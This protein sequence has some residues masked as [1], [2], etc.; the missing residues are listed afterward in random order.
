MITNGKSSASRRSLTVETINRYI[1]CLN[2]VVEKGHIST[3]DLKKDIMDELEKGKPFEI[4]KKT[5]KKI[6]DNL[7]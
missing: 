2:K 1:F 7:E 3:I 6:V 4:D 5:L